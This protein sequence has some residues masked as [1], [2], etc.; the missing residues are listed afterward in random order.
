M[1]CTIYYQKIKHGL[2][3]FDASV[4]LMSKVMFE[5]LGYLALSTTLMQVQLVDSSI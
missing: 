4:N 5:Q 3:D 1:T 2:C